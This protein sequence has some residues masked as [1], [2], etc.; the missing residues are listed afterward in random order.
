MWLCNC[1]LKSGV[2]CC[3]SLGDRVGSFWSEKDLGKVKT[4]EWRKVASGW[5]GFQDQVVD[6]FTKPLMTESFNKLKTLLEMTNLGKLN[7]RGMLKIKLNFKEPCIKCHSMRIMWKCLEESKS[8][9][10][11]KVYG[12]IVK[13]FKRLLERYSKRLLE[14]CVLKYVEI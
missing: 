11:F 4:L 6:I 2:I 12:L 1:R 8:L 5:K 7:L 13:N 9:L 10:L 14:I 3:W